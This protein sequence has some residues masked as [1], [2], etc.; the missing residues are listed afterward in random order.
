[1]GFYGG[2]GKKGSG[3]SE[4]LPASIVYC[5]M[6]FA[7]ASGMIP[8]VGWHFTTTQQTSHSCHNVFDDSQ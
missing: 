2:K 6:T 4:L 7:L 5:V 8:Q 1:V 3:L